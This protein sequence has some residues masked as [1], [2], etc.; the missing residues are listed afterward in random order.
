MNTLGT[1]FRWAFKTRRRGVVS[2]LAMMFLVLFGSLGLAMAITSQGNLRTAATQLQVNRALAAAETGLDV[3]RAR[4]EEAT[5]RFIVARG[6]VDQSFGTKLWAGTLTSGDGVVNVRPPTGGYSEFTSPAGIIQ[7]L[8]N[9]HSADQNVVVFAGATAQPTI[10]DAPTGADRNAYLTS[11]WLV[12]PPI[13]IDAPAANNPAA[14][15]ITYAPLANG[16]DIRV[17]VTGFSSVGSNGTNFLYAYDGQTQRP[18]SRTIQQD[19]R[20]AKR[21]RHAIVSPSRVLIGKNVQI[22]GNMG[23]NYDQTGFTNGE[24][25]VIKSD[26]F[27]LDPILDTK[28]NQFYAGVRTRGTAGDNRL[29]VDHPTESLGIPSNAQDFNNDGRPDNAFA[30]ITGDR[31]VDEFDIFIRHYDRNGDG[32]VALSAALRRG[33]PYENLATE[34]SGDED[35]ALAIDSADPDRNRNGISGFANPADNFALNP[36]G[37]PL[38]AD[39]VRLGWRDG[40]IDKKDRYAK[41]RG[42]LMFRA[43][44]SQWTNDRGDPN[45]ALRGTVLPTDGGSARRYGA[46]EDELPVIDANTFSNAQSGLAARADGDTFDAQVARQLGVAASQLPTYTET[47]TDATAPRFW[48]ANLDNA[49]VRSRTGRD[50]WE[51]MP[52]NSPSFW[53]W[54]IRPRYENMTFKNVK[55]P[56]GNNGLFIN[57]TFVGVTLVDADPANTHPNWALYGRLRWDANAQRPIAV[58]D[59]L[60]KSDFARYTTGNVIDGPANYAQ[61]PDPPT[62]GGVVRTG[63]ARD[64]KLYSNNVRFHDSLFVGS[65]VSTMPQGF[66]HTRNKIQ[67]TGSTRFT[68]QHPSQPNNAALNPDP[69]DRAEIAKSSLMMPNYSV[70]IGQFNAPT[71]TYA[72]GPTGQSVNLKGTIVAGVLDA[73][74]NTTIDGSLLATFSPSLGTAPLV[75]NGIPVGNPADFNVSL[76]YLGTAEGES[77]SIDPNT[78]PSFNGQR[79]VGWDLDGDGL[80][81]MPHSQTPSAAQMSAGA[82]RV[83]FYGYG[84]IKLNFNPDRPMPEGIMIRLSAVPLAGTYREGKR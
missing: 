67:F 30:D 43:S 76:G 21:H 64:T 1:T 75:S 57:C 65:I 3:A 62:I 35:L 25:T 66:T 36:T 29:R 26:F 14:F 16:T 55:I 15:Q 52:L 74:G 84:R 41:V 53:D 68:D 78:L 81:D 79:W 10:T 2:V 22:T 19:F 13:G 51:R 61:F 77:E 7:A 83:P 63:A 46:P 56:R 9:A 23:I 73:R 37:R 42:R 38:D 34:F 59:A 32:M 50:L 12:T 11:N 17:I 45:N 24:P 40:V 71:D 69:E 80:P 6:N 70:D 33:G 8:R 27:G 58:T 4:L 54:Y 5:A 44:Q 60:D 20:I 49:Y 48:R 28:L 47:K 39:D 72:G 31:A 18:L 82:T